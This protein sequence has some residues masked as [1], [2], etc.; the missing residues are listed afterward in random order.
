M[1]YSRRRF[2]VMSLRHAELLRLQKNPHGSATYRQAKKNY[3]HTEPYIHLTHVERWQF[4]EELADS[5]ASWKSARLFA[6]C[7]DKLHF[8]PT[9]SRQTIDE[10]AF[11]QIISRFEQ[12]LKRKDK[13]TGTINYG[14]TIHDNNQ[15]VALKHTELMKKF[16]RQGT[17]FT[18]ITNII[19]TPL[20]VDSQL[21]SM[22]QI[23]DVCALAIRHYL[24]KGDTNLFN[25]IF[26]RADTIGKKVV[27]VRHYTNSACNCLICQAHR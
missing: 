11:E 22:I 1:D 15:T 10:Q 7:I 12:C 25:R 18:D 27:G 24:E 20:F 26:S 6:E 17:L 13:Y 14:L 9:R 23:A 3:E 5:V 2:E 19:E 4:V 21:T 16:H 8:D